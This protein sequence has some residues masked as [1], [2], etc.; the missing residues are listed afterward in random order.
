M[1]TPQRETE[2]KL[3]L[4]DESL[5]DTLVTELFMG[6]MRV[7]QQYKK[8]DYDSTYYDTAD[9][10]LLKNGLALRLRN[11]GSGFIATVKDAGTVSG[12]LFDRG[13]WNVPVEE[14]AITPALFAA[15]PIGKRLAEAVAGA[16]LEPLMQTVFSR[17]SADW[18]AGDNIIELAA[19]KGEV[20]AGGHRAPLCEIELELKD[21]DIS[22]LLDCGARLA[23]RYPLL[24][25]AESKFQ[26]GLVL[27]GLDGNMIPAPS[28]Q[29]GSDGTIR[30]VMTACLT[31][32]LHKALVKQPCFLDTPEDPETAHQFRVS[33][34]KLRAILSFAKPVMDSPAYKQISKALRALAKDF[35]YVRELDVLLE[36]HFSSDSTADQP[37]LGALLQAEQQ[38]ERE[39]LFRAVSA[40]PATAVLL[41][42]WQTLLDEAWTS[43]AGDDF[44]AYANKRLDKWTQ[45]FKKRLNND[46]FSNI[47]E[48]HRLR[49]LGKKIRYVQEALGE[50]GGA[51]GLLDKTQLKKLQTLLGEL[52]DADR[53]IH[54]AGTLLKTHPEAAPDITVFMETQRAEMAALTKKIRKTIKS[55]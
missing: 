18:K 55:K 11:T 23:Q 32:A 9:H 19:D 14:A 29:T 12:G 28:V 39:R 10:G 24:A 16:P 37:V 45:R 8:A 20:I 33:I 44:S 21:G 31:E 51:A 17:V 1:M 34:R 36:K 27:A 46:T 43:A 26:R 3:R 41:T 5:Y 53:N 6:D 49:I 48:T 25:E 7:S 42:V 2:L 15:F 35:S 47:E 50:T 54:I 40:R 22:A 52:C 30:Q 4:I 38:K 13:E